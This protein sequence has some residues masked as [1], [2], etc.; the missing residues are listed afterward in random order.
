MQL[1]IARE[2]LRRCPEDFLRLFDIFH[3]DIDAQQHGE[4]H[5]VLRENRIGD[6][7]SFAGR[8]EIAG[9]GFR[10][11][12]PVV[13]ASAFR[14]EAGGL[15]IALRGDDVLAAI[16]RGLRLPVDFLKLGQRLLRTETRGRAVR[17]PQRGSKENPCGKSSSHRTTQRTGVQKF[18][19]YP[20][21]RAGSRVSGC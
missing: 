15:M 10:N 19:S 3:G 4:R 8:G 6:F 21:W 16:E 14:S 9:G 5:D 12:E 11:A 17:G 7:E 13:R 1:L 18:N 2:A 20:S